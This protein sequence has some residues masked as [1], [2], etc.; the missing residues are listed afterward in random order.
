MAAKKKIFFTHHTFSDRQSKNLSIMNSIVH[1]GKIS[2]TDIS[3]NLD[4]NLVT[5]SNYI[6]NFLEKGLVFEGATEISTGGR[7]PTLVGVNEK[8]GYSI[9]V[10]VEPS[11][12]SAILTDQNAKALS[13]AKIAPAD[14]SIGNPKS[15]IS[16]LIN[17]VIGDAKVDK[18]RIR[19]IGL[20]IPGVIDYADSTVREEDLPEGAKGI[21]YLSIRDDI[22][23]EF[24]IN[25]FVESSATCAAFGEKR[26]NIEADVENIL[27]LYSDLG[28]GIII[29]GESYYGVS[30]AE[31]MK[32][33]GRAGKNPEDLSYLRP[34]GVDLGIVSEARKIIDRGIGSDILK[35]ANGK[36]KDVSLETIVKARE[37]GDRV[38]NELVRTASV[39]LGT[40]T[41][42]LINLFAPDVVFLGGGL[43]KL[44]DVFLSHV[45][46]TIHK[47]A[48]RELAEKT[49]VVIA[50]LGGDAVAL[51]A[52]AMVL[53][54]TFL[55][56]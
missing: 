56:A 20:G 40:R 32:A 5:V 37:D 50:S 36:L 55:D 3:K 4:L 34:F 27:Y 28:W 54:E 18:E 45:K 49:K 17:K 21:D 22:G 43:E 24:G 6:N 33:A 1:K 7:P 30:E 26:L 35:V 38:A 41:A 52:A 25:T 39:N 11:Y 2:R 12:V 8:G 13:R 46:D 9:G 31:E 16:D 23:E 48:L 42:Y 29:K 15:T 19:G 44:G 47:F 53:R 51:G 14:G 10:D